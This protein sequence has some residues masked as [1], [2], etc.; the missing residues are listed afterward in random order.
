MTTQKILSGLYEAAKRLNK[1]DSEAFNTFVSRGMRYTEGCDKTIPSFTTKLAILV[2][3]LE[4]DLR[5]G[6][7]KKSGKS[8]ALVAAKRILKS[9]QKNHLSSSEFCYARDTEDGQF[10][11]DGYRLLLLKD[12]D[13]LPLEPMPKKY[14][15]RLIINWLFRK[16]SLVS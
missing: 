10:I 15:Q 6:E 14:N 9:A 2:L 12:V 16:P 11:T 4:D 3:N 1:E 5:K 13:K 7:S 8:T